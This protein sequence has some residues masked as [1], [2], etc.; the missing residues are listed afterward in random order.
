MKIQLKPR[1]SFENVLRSTWRIFTEDPAA[2]LFYPILQALP[3]FLLT[4]YVSFSTSG[5]S[6]FTPQ[7]IDN[8]DVEVIS[9]YIPLFVIMY[10]IAILL[11]LFTPIF[12][13]IKTDDSIHNKKNDIPTLS[14]RALQRFLPYVG[15]SVI[16]VIFLILLFILLIIPAIIAGVY[17]MFTPMIVALRGKFALDALTYSYRIVKGKWWKVLGYSILFGIMTGIPTS[18][19]SALL[20]WR[21]NDVVLL[22]II[23]TTIQVV[24]TGFSYVFYVVFFLF[25]E[26]EYLLKQ[27]DEEPQAE[28]EPSA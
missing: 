17:W 9:Q 24:I 5:R 8:W 16:Q 23:T 26:K 22:T 1:F 25:L 2:F 7:N 6:T 4:I 27:T 3:V 10:L 15:T 19:V 11:G 18:I 28:E 14:K 21:V 12:I 13:A 20:Q